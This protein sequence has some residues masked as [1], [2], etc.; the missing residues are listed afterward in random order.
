[1]QKHKNSTNLIKNKKLAQKFIPIELITGT[2]EEK[3]QKIQSFIQSK[4]LAQSIESMSRE[5]LIKG[6]S[7]I[8]DYIKGDINEIP[9]IQ[10][11]AKVIIN[12]LFAEYSFSPDTDYSSYDIVDGY[13]YNNDIKYYGKNYKQF[14]PWA[15]I[16]N[17]TKNLN[18]YD[19]NNI[20]PFGLETFLENINKK[21]IYTDIISEKAKA[22]TEKLHGNPMYKDSSWVD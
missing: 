2:D 15:N 19:I 20:F 18:D 7:N 9:K 4:K 1:M 14:P 5:L 6:L 11:P 13:N 17:I 21:K 8:V 12:K 22:D 16:E 10:S 3:E